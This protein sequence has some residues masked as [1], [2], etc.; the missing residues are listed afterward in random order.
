[1]T[2]SVTAV[3]SPGFFELAYG[4]RDTPFSKLPPIHRWSNTSTSIPFRHG[5]K[6]PFQNPKPGKSSH[7]SFLTGCCMEVFFTFLGL[8][9]SSS[10]GGK[11]ERKHMLHR[12][13]LADWRGRERRIISSTPPSGTFTLFLPSLPFASFGTAVARPGTRHQAPGTSLYPVA[14][15]FKLTVVFRRDVWEEEITIHGN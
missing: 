12:A 1:M 10:P 4:V 7:P 14:H 3:Y 8:I 6:E 9:D 11:K 5:P 13:E 2:L 15:N